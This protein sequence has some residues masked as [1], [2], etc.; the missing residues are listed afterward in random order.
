MSSDDNDHEIKKAED[1][2]ALYGHAYLLRTKDGKLKAISP[3]D[4]LRLAAQSEEEI[5][6]DIELGR[7]LIEKYAP[8]RSRKPI[9][10][11]ESNPG[12]L[13]PYFDLLNEAKA[14]M[15]DWFFMDFDQPGETSE[16]R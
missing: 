7:E 13:D 2:L 16:E 6:K 5:Q 9:T 1:D 12:D 15:R 8:S 3:E 4:A 10:V 14:N 11:I